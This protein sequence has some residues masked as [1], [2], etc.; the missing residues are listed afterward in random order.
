MER[1]M[2]AEKQVWEM[3]DIELQSMYRDIMLKGTDIQEAAELEFRKQGDRL[4]TTSCWWTVFMSRFKM[5]AGIDI[6]PLPDTQ[7]ARPAE[8]AQ[9]DAESEFRVECLSFLGIQHGME[10]E[11][12]MRFAKRAWWDIFAGRAKALMKS[13]ADEKLL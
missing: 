3:T 5:E 6:P 12:I 11:E 13:V 10:P 4:K 2:G 7:L 9:E 8:S 1:I